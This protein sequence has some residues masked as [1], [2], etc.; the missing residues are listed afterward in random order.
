MIAFCQEAAEIPLIMAVDEEGGEI[1]RISSN[2][3]LAEERFLSPRELYE[4]GGLDAVREDAE[5]KGALL[6]KLGLNLNL[7][8]VADVSQ[9]PLDYIYARTLGLNAEETALYV[10][11]V[12][13]G[14]QSGGVASALKHFPG[15][16]NNVNT[17]IGIAV[18][19]RPYATF[20]QSDFL[21]FMAGIQAGAECVMVSHNIVECMDPDNPASLS[22]AVHEILRNELGF[23]GLILTDDLSMKAVSDASGG[24]GPSVMAVLAGNDIL[25]ASDAGDTYEALLAAVES[26]AV[27]MQTIDRAVC[28]ILA[29]KYAKGL[30]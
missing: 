19:R 1:V 21:P 12:V 4:A 15:Y 2:P 13:G 20:E 24:A 11:A 30:L 16:G 10:A 14:A 27:P 29:F 22:P 18:D 28:R 3:N 7:A 9:S 8:P 26:G 25:L 23:T 6:L 17:H 5:K